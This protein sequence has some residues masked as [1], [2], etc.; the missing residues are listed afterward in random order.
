VPIRSTV[1][2]FVAL[3]SLLACHGEENRLGISSNPGATDDFTG[4]GQVAEWL[5]LNPDW[6]V[7]LGGIWVGDTNYLISGGNSPGTWSWNS[8]FI[9][10]L[11]VDAEKLVGWK[12]AEF[13]VEFLQFNGQATNQ[14]AGSAQGYN[15]LPGPDPLDRSELYQLWWRQ[16]LF[17]G[18]LIFR[19]GKLVPTDDFNNVLRPVPEQD[20]ALAIPAVTGLAFT[21]VFVNSTLLG[22]M[23]GYYNSAC[24]VTVTIAPTRQTYISYGFYD[25]NV[26]AGA[27]TGMLGPQFNGYYFQILEAGGAWEI[28]GL[29]GSA[30]LGGWLQTG[31]MNGGNGSSESGASGFYLFGSQ[32]LW[33]RHPGKDNSGLSAFAQFGA[34]TSS[35]LPFREYLGAGLTA[36]GLVPGR[37]EDSAGAGMALAWLNAN[38]FNRSSELMFQAYYQAHIWNGIYAQPVVSFIPT[39]GGGSDLDPAWALTMRVSVLF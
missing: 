37:P 10:G 20:Q 39:P 6:G 25:G 38:D 13:G 2:A 11:T 15:S 27:Q 36:F 22:V 35:T 26:A 31:E 29:P 24:G 28:A 21:P 19:I 9:A 30:G 16:E 33:L 4:T 23:P 3:A 32:R 18:K 1:C 5:G 34:N 17:D 8:L 14:Q 7:R 12:G